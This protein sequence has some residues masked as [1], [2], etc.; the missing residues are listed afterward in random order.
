MVD[1]DT[2]GSS[3]EDYEYILYTTILK[4]RNPNRLIQLQSTFKRDVAISLTCKLF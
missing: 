3:A 1:Q 2:L 4:S